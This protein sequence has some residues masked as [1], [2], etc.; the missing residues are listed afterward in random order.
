MNTPTILALLAGSALTALVLWSLQASSSSPSAAGRSTA[1]AVSQAATAG[2][3]APSPRQT[4]LSASARPGVDAEAALQEAELRARL[5]QGQVNALQGT[6]TPWPDDLSAGH[7]PE[8]IRQMLVRA[9]VERGLGTLAAMDCDEYPCVALIQRQAAP[10]DWVEQVKSALSPELEAGYLPQTGLGLWANSSGEGDAQQGQIAV[11]I[12]PAG[13][14]GN[15][16]TRL[17]T[18]ARD[19]LEVGGD[20]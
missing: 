1:S 5:L 18:R 14:D 11:A 16:E 19:L 6:P 10:S 9:V 20:R 12:V 17:N 13:G 4:R 7:Q 15:A 8:A 2:N 3:S